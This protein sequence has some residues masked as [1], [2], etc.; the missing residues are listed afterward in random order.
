MSKELFN[1]QGLK[2]Y[3]PITGGI[4]GKVVAQVHAVDDVTFNILEGESLGLVGESGCGKTTLGRCL[5]KLTEPT[6]GEIIY[7]GQNFNEF[8]KSELKE[9]R[10]ETAMIFQDPFLSLHPRMTIGEI[11]GEPYVI[12]GTPDRQ[13]K[14]R[15]VTNWIR[16]VGLNPYH[17][18]R[19]PHQFSGGQK[20]RIGIARAMA[21]NPGFIV[22]DE[23]VAALDVSVR[24]SIINLMKDLQK[25]F[26]L[27]CLF[28]SHDI[29]VVRQISDR[30]IVMYV[31]KIVESARV[32]E[33]F[34]DT[35]HP[36]TKALLASVPI[37]DPDLKRDRIVLDGDVPTSITPPS[38]CRFHPRC[39]ERMPICSMKE[40]KTTVVKG[41]H[42]VSCHLYD[43]L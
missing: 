30:I 3:F 37:P 14:Q 40:P 19:Y 24:A 42:T 36:Y 29:A 13:D 32:P 43:D 20:Q 12:H 17:I 8:D 27:T 25:K 38:G 4:L 5:I 10:R 26:D 11:I 28:I 39:P 18:Y 35:M 9:F 7:K 23:P 34:D 2:K 16:T 33:I 31:G 15:L 6:A 22:A 41:D 1:I 21:L